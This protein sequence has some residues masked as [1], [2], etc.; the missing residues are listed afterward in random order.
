M[1][2]VAIPFGSTEQNDFIHFSQKGKLKDEQKSYWSNWV[3]Q[4]VEY[5]TL[6][7]ISGHDL[8]DLSP[9][10]SSAQTLSMGSASESLSPFAP[11]PTICV[12]THTL[13]LS[14]KSEQKKWM[15]N[16]LL[17]HDIDFPIF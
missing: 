2:R 5:P 7:F 1:Q 9:H 13:S 17:S 16:I 14:N 15:T 4:S 10:W 3:P 12:H 6:G 11:P 8:S